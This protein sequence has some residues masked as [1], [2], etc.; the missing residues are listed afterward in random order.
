ML[1]HAKARAFEEGVAFDL[2]LDWLMEMFGHITHCPVL[3]IKIDWSKRGVGPSHHSPTIDK[4]IGAHGYTKGNVVLISH[5]ANA[6][7]SDATPEELLL[8]C[9]HHLRRLAERSTECNDADVLLPPA[10]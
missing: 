7:K 1:S 9:A 6:M 4:L 5:K 2:T 10:F 8:F 3:G